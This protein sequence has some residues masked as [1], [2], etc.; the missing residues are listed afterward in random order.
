MLIKKILNW[1][2]GFE[3]CIFTKRNSNWLDVQPKELIFLFPI[4]NLS[5]LFLHKLTSLNADI[6]TNSPKSIVAKV[7]CMVTTEGGN[8]TMYFPDWHQW[9][10]ELILT[11]T[12]IYRLQLP[13]RSSA[14]SCAVSNHTSGNGHI[15]KG[16]L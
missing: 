8:Q 13:R 1:N 7:H 9:I 5:Y 4:K 6:R 10:L 11:A 12:L 3:S 2:K 15:V 14:H 16:P